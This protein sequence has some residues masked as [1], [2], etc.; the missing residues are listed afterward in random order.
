MTTRI[1]YSNRENPV[2]LPGQKSLQIDHYIVVF[3]F[4]RQSTA[5]FARQAGLFLF[6]FLWKIIIIAYYNFSVLL[7]PVNGYK[8]ISTKN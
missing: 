6:L 7:F 1:T 5:T 2:I 8:T 3:G 4:N